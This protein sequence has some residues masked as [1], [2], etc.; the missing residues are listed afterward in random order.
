GQYVTFTF[1]AASG[2]TN[3]GLRYSAGSGAAT[4]KIELDGAVIAANQTF[5]ATAGWQKWATLTL[6][7]NLSVNGP[8]ILKI[9][10]DTPAGSNQYIN[11]DNLTIAA[12]SGS[13]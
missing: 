10:F 2:P 8:H 1:N 4:R 11:L 13:S 6:T 5:P 9:W 3:L 7:P 12:T